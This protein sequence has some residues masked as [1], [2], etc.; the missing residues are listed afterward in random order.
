[1]KKSKL[2]NL[3]LITIIIASI[4]IRFYKLGSLPAILNRDEAALAYNAVLLQQTGLDEW[5]RSWPFSLE[6]F[7]DW[8]LPGYIYSL[9]VLF[10]FLPTADWVVKIP[11]VLAGI[12]ITFLAYKI[13]DKLKWSKFNK[14]LVTFLISTTPIFFFYSRIAFEAHLGLSLLILAL[15]LILLPQKNTKNRVLFDLVGL[16]VWFAAAIT[17]NTPLLLIPLLLPIIIFARGY[18]NVKKWLCSVLTLL[19]IFL[20]LLFNQASLASQKSSITIFNDETYWAKSVEYY[21]SFSG[22]SQTVFGNKY[23]FYTKE[24]ISNTF[25]S[26]SYDYLVLRGGYHPLHQLPD[27]GHLLRIVYFTSL[28]GLIVATF[29]IIKNLSKIKLKNLDKWIDKFKLELALVYLTFISLA[30]AIITVDAPHATRSLL[31]FF[32]TP[33]LSVYFIKR[34]KKIFS[35]IF[36]LLALGCFS[37]YVYSYFSIYPKYQAGLLQYDYSKTINKVDSKTSGRVA[38]IDPD[39]YLYILTAWYL[40]MN[41]QEYLDNNVRQLP[42][43]YG[44]RYG[45]Q[46]GKYHFYAQ[47]NDVKDSNTP[48]IEWEN[49]QWIVSGL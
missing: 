26:F 43:S 41:P 20:G 34:F 3:F 22:I 45:E 31:F 29:V 42:N 2:I 14:L 5:G 33:F 17:Y 6:S 32:I 24:I 19:I 44:F 21:D 9:V 36:I 4:G 7:G 15:Y 46:V 39:G 16:A 28:A 37:Y 8:K 18:K 1:M 35:I 13:A 38:I 48:I 47:T 25:K 40:K 10:S 23:I 49:N 12:L 11:S 30:P 27:W